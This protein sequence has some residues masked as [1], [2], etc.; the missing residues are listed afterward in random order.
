MK[1]CSEHDQ[2]KHLSLQPLEVWWSEE[3]HTHPSLQ[4]FARQYIAARYGRHS[5][6]ADTAIL[7]RIKHNHRIIRKCQLLQKKI[8]TLK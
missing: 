8:G 1:S 3:M 7:S 5:E 4:S 2:T 6:N